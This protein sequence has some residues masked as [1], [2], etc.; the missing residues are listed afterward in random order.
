MLLGVYRRQGCFERLLIQH[1]YQFFAFALVLIIL[2]GSVFT[3]G[4]LEPV[5]TMLITPLVAVLVVICSYTQKYLKSFFDLRVLKVK[6]IYY[7]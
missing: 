5:V 2:M 6:N 3:S 4:I 1:N 7:R